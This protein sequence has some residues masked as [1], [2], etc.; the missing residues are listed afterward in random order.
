MPPSIPGSVIVRNTPLA[1]VAW[2]LAAMVRRALPL[3]AGRVIVDGE[4]P[5]VY[6]AW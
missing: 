4:A 6:S 2:M 3:D 5:A 1:S